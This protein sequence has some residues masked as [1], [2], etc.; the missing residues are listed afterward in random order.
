MT[1]SQQINK[2]YYYLLGMV[3]EQGCVD[4]TLES[5]RRDMGLSV[6]EMACVVRWLKKDGTL[7]V[8]RRPTPSVATRLHIKQRCSYVIPMK[9]TKVT[10]QPSIIEDLFGHIGSKPVVQP[11]PPEDFSVSTIAKNVVDSV[12]GLTAIVQELQRQNNELAQENNN[13]QSRLN[14]VM[15]VAQYA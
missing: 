4:K 12:L 6:S 13:L 7:T 1:I 2:V 3:N 14:K 5:I 10:T 11:P 15:E 9:E 8:V